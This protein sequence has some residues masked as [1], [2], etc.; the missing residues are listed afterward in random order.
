MNLPNDAAEFLD[1][2]RGIFRNKHVD[3][4]FTLPRIHVYGFSKAQDPEFDFHEKIRIALSEV[5]FEVQMHKVRLVAPGKWML[6]ASFVLP[7]TVAFAK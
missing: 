5:A 1:S 2:F 4:Q 6:C 3:K 7:E